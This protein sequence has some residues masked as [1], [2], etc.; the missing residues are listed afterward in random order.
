M[1]SDPE[2]GELTDDQITLDYR[3]FQR[4]HGH[5]FSIDDVMTAYVAHEAE[6]KPELAV[7]LGSGLGSVLHMLAWR[8]PRAR[9]IAIEAQDASFSLLERNVARNGLSDRCELFHGD[10]REVCGRE[11]QVRAALVT[12]TPPYFPASSALRAKDAQRTFAR[13]EERGGIEAYVAAG[14][15]LLDTHGALVLCADA[16]AEPR[17]LGA[18]AQAGLQVCA[19]TW[20]IPKEGKAALFGVWTL[21]H[22]MRLQP[23]ACAELES[24]PRQQS[25]DQTAEPITER[26]LTLRTASGAVTP[27]ANQLRAFSGFNPL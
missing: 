25:A 8:M 12:G 9:F 27:E 5:R 16:R 21:R 15:R 7:D 19:V 24:T 14:A 26:R 17:L 22:S 20:A 10:L 4:K 6:P 2:L 3:V 18:S 11:V 13:I 1:I 23:G